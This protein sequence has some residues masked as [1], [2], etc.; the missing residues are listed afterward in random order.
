MLIKVPIPVHPILLFVPVVA[1]YVT[2]FTTLL[3]AA[4]KFVVKPFYN[5]KASDYDGMSI[6]SFSS[7]LLDVDWEIENFNDREL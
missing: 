1:Y 7:T 5:T 6:T 3:A 4:G 2:H